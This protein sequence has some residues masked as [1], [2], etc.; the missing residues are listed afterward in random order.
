MA[1]LPELPPRWREDVVHV[2]YEFLEDAGL[3]HT[4]TA[5]EEETGGSASA[6]HGRGRG[7]GGDGDDEEEEELRFLRRLV[8]TGDWDACE[9]FIAPTESHPGVPHTTMT[10]H[11]RRQRFLEM[12]DAPRGGEAGGGGGGDDDD[13]DASSSSH[14]DGKKQKKK[15][16]NDDNGVDDLVAALQALEP[17]V[18]KAQFNDLCFLMTLSEPRD[19]AV[20]CGGVHSLVHVLRLTYKEALS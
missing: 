6:G 15:N 10:A 8:M 20:G 12:L 19:H 3:A 9:A 13:D 17:L 1:H 5:L 4:L 11:I 14:H 18:D 16:N 7:R 2:L